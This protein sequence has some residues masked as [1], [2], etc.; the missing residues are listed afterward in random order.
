M[1]DRDLSDS[2]VRRATVDFLDS[3]KHDI[4]K[5]DYKLERM[6]EKHDKL[7]RRFAKLEGQL[8]AT[9]PNLITKDTVKV[10]LADQRR[11]CQETFKAHNKKHSDTA[12]P[13]PVL[14][15][16]MDINFFKKVIAPVVAALAG[17]VW[18]VIELINRF[19]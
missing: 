3:L 16:G 1:P 11:S 5:L 2:S 12:I 4:R 17:I 18:G 9:L 10:M 13:K 14:N 7:D 15:S 6:D 8:D 19:K